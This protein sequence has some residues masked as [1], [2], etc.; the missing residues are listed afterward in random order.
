[1]V[2]AGTQKRGWMVFWEILDE[3]QQQSRNPVDFCM[4]NEDISVAR[5]RSNDCDNDQVFSASLG[6]KKERR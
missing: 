5:L 1:M 6:F 2:P 3:L 4:Q